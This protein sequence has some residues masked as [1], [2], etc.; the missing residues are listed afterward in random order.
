MGLSISPATGNAVVAFG[1]V[2]VSG[3]PVYLIPG[4]AITTLAT[5]SRNANTVSYGA[6]YV[7]TPITI[8]QLALEVT[9]QA[10]AGHTA[11]M[12]I[13]N[14][15]INWHPT[16]LIVDAGTVAIDSTGVKTASVGVT[17]AAGRYFM[18]LNQSATVTYRS[19]KSA[20]NLL[21]LPAALGANMNQ[22]PFV[23]QAYGAFPSTADDWTTLGG[24]TTT[25]GLYMMVLRV[26]TP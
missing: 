23:T 26:S 19:W 21:G 1:N 7:A 17:L 15:S 18:A 13:Y 8:D 24:D 10:T 12:A 9:T 5:Q 16:S 6:I 11:R 22:Y 14:A 20:G 4:V 3:T 2:T 25:G